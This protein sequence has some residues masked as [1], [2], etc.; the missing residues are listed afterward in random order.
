MLYERLRKTLITVACMLT[1]CRYY[2]VLYIMTGAKIFG[3]AQLDRQQA[4]T[5]LKQLTLSNLIDPSWVSMEKEQNEVYKLKIKA[6][7]KTAEIQA[8]FLANN[9]KIEEIGGYWII[10]KP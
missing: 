5:L 8:F 10:S 1:G 3:D 2:K 9:L 4:M 6:A 7:P